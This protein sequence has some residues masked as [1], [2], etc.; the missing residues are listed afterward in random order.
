MGKWADLCKSMAKFFGR[1]INRTFLAMA[2]HEHEQAVRQGGE[3]GLGR[4]QGRPRKLRLP[5][6]ITDLLLAFRIPAKLL[7]LATNMRCILSAAPLC[8][9]DVVAAVFSGGS[10]SGSGSS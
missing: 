10:R 2:Y 8:C 9:A 4:V 5:L 3:Q 1:G 7:G 6:L